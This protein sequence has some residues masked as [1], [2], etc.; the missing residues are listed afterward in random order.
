MFCTEYSI[1]VKGHLL[2]PSKDARK[3]NHFTVV[4][5]MEM[6][7]RG[8]VTRAVLVSSVKK[9]RVGKLIKNVT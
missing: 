9:G 5:G 7:L 2:L 8:L 6:R 4:A 3:V 1:F